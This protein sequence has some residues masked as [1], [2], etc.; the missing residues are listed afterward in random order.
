MCLIL[1]LTACVHF[2]SVVER[3]ANMK[4][5]CVRFCEVALKFS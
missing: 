1:I 3:R 5:N 4:I 2:E